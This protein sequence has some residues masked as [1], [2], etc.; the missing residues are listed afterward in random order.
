VQRD[1]DREETVRRRLEEYAQKTEPLKR[2]YREKGLVAEVD[3][4]GSPESILLA[5]KRSLGR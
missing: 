4:V 2:Y 1:D 3:G 5:T